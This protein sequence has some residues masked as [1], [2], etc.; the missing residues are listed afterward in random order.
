MLFKYLDRNLSIW[1]KYGDI[2]LLWKLAHDEQEE[3]R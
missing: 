2:V 3:Y 1:I